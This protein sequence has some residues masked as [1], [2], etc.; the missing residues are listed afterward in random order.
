[1]EA[2]E[3]QGLPSA[4]NLYRVE[5]CPGSHIRIRQMADAGMSIESDSEYAESGQVTHS[6][7]ADAQPIRKPTGEEQEIADE[8][9]TLLTDSFPWVF[10][11]GDGAEWAEQRMW[12]RDDSFKR[13]FSAKLDLVAVSPDQ[14]ALVVDYKTGWLDYLPAWNSWQITGQI[15]VAAEWDGFGEVDWLSRGIIGCIIAPRAPRGKRITQTVVMPDQFDGARQ[16]VLKILAA[17]RQE[18]I[19]GDHCKFC[20]AKLACPEFKESGLS[21]LDLIKTPPGLLP[22][23]DGI[24]KGTRNSLERIP[25]AELELILNRV[26]MC[27]WLCDAIESE[28]RARLRINPDYFSGKWIMGAPS[29][30]RAISD[31]GTTFKI[32][33]SNLGITADQFSAICDVGI[34]NVEKLVRASTGKSAKDTKEYVNQLLANAI[35][36]VPRNASLERVR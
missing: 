21:F 16:A 5:A 20:P 3:R 12:L 28:A 13:A 17:Q 19:P 35:V 33:N 36:K 26:D 27:R 25:C 18:W 31:V 32:L 30:V 14:P 15:A 24:K 29:S 1:M 2:N 4:S 9:R 10:A 34:G 22:S 6:L 23:L 8:C 11:S 7:L